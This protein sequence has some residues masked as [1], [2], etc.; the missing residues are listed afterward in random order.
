MQPG[1]S[2]TVRVR[3]PMPS[4]GGD[5]VDTLSIGSSGG[6]QVAVPMIL[7]A[8]VPV[9]GRFTGT[10]TGGNARAFSPAQTFTYAFDVPKGKRDVVVNTTLS[11]D[12]KDLLEG[13]LIDP[14]GESQSVSSNQ[15]V[16]SAK[17]WSMTNTVATPTPGRWRFVVVVQNPVTGNEFAQP[18][19]GTVAFNQ[20]KVSA[21]SLPAQL[22]KGQAVTEQVKVTN[23][24]KAPM[25]VQT[26]ARLD[27]ST[28]YQ[29]SPQVAGSTIPLP[30]SVDDL[31]NI[32]SYLVP[33]DT[34]KLAVT[35]SATV[36]AQVELQSPTGGIDLFGNLTAAQHGST[37]STAT[38]SESTPT[39][40]LGLWGPYLQQ[41]GP[42]GDG[43]AP[44]GSAVLSATG[45]MNRFDPAVTS[46]TGDVFLKTLDSSASAGTPLVIALVR[47]RR[48]R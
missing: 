40:G 36:P 29:L 3:V 1:A 5:G 25:V 33:P 17:G 8:V 19:S 18:F 27:S 13:I 12:P 47:P 26:D 20:V 43:G 16:A 32:P 15:L 11:K 28:T 21:P 31:S 30:L 41:I 22:T 35:S 7:R 24:G 14:N 10:I 34:T 38:V 23:T 37:V 46:S 6:H 2:A 44:S 39:V 4:A 9:P 48:S 42:Y 45:T